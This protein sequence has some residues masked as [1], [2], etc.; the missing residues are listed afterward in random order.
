MFT[1]C[2]HRIYK[3]SARGDVKAVRRLQRRL[4]R[5]SSA[6][7]LSVRPCNTR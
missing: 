2:S 7:C 3:A 1:S 4:M 6:K 5:S